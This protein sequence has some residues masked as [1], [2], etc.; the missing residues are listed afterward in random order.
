MKDAAQRERALDVR[1]SFIVQAPAGSGKTDLLVRRFLKLLATAKKPEEILAITFTKK[2]AAEM[3]K[4]ILKELPNSAEVAHRLRIQTIDAFCAALTRQV[5]VLARFGAQ[6]EIIE[7][8]RPLYKEAAGR[9]FEE[10]NPATERLLAHLDNNIPLAT[11]QLAKMLESR[12]R[13]LRKT[14]AVPTRQELEATLVSE[15]NR[16]L[17]KAKALYPKASEALARGF[18]TQKG[19]WTKR[20]PPPPEFV[21][22]A[23][24][25]E[26]LWA[27]YNMPPEK[28]ED[29]Q[30]EALEAILALLKPAVA[31]LKVLFGERG[32]AD[33]TEFAHGALAA[34]GSVDDPSDL[35]LSLDQKISHILVDEFQDTSL[36]QYELLVK[37][38]SGWSADDGRT[39]F[40]VGDPM[41]SIYRFREAEVSLFLRAKH[42]GVGSVS[43]EPIELSTNRRS[44]EGLVEWFNAAFPR[45]L[46]SQE[47]QTSGAVPYL[48]ATPFEPKL[49]G[50]AVSWHCGYDREAEAAQVVSIVKSS[51]GKKAI[52]VRNRAHLDEIVPALKEAGVRF[53]A[54]DIEQLGEKQVV[55]DLYALTRALLHLGDRIAWLALLR[56]PWC[57]LTLADLLALSV[58]PPDKGGSEFTSGGF[59]VFDLLNDSVHLS[60]DGYA[61]VSRLRDVLKPLIDNRLRGSLRERVEGA[62]LALGGP[63]CVESATDL[64][65]AEIFLD[66]LERLEEA[67]EVDLAALEDRIKGRLYALPDVEAP[68]DAVEIMTIHR[69]KG[70]EFDHVIVPGLDRLPRSGPKPLLVWKSLV[71][72]VLRPDSGVRSPRPPDKGAANE[73]SGGSLLLAP[74]DETGAGED[75]TYKYVRELDKDAD[76]IESG[77][78]FY[79]AATRAKQRLHLL[80]CAKA[81]ED[82][83]ARDPSKR[84]L[85]SKIWW[86]ARAHFGPAPADAIAEPERMPIRDVLQRLPAGF[87]VP[88]APTSVKWS[89]PEDGR[90]EEEIEFSWAGETARHVGTVVHRWLQRIADDELREWDVKR[91]DALRKKFRTELERRGVPL[92]DIKASLEAVG[93]G[94]KNAISD[95]RGR[96]ILGPHLE[97]RSEH[98]LRVSGKN[99]ARNYVIDRLFRDTSGERWIVD[100]KISSHEGGGVEAFLD[101]Q[102]KRYE[103]Q[104][105]AYAALFDRAR[106]GLYFPLLRGW[107]RWG[108]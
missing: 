5:P 67:G 52:L 83:A 25:R 10:F 60:P 63:A 62:W 88:G 23:G 22:I 45:V 6:P 26:A 34:L 55:Q 106:L 105:N 49:D 14:G 27:L 61:R 84:S 97:A 57:G 81:T 41:Q 98:R 92:R 4:R 54:L 21:Q 91:V 19:E 68:D 15:R 40:L 73:V 33:F 18:L 86:Q 95:E 79:V 69:A 9:V 82:L 89:A 103:P 53:K 44:Q 107:R 90:Q 59:L 102:Q 66:E 80:A 30:W 17:H 16:L 11:D 24:L 99:G 20:S 32:Q 8:A 108:A 12:D 58:G 96:W 64:E 93:G 47:D 39:L 100:F 51:P 76:D 31:Q 78:L 71:S 72:S 101:E 56:A 74:I 13:W 1:H 29:R 38:T 46:P 75:P 104:L 36:S 37:L 7:D 28:Y 35:L 50:T 2:A 43:L 94:L 65:D 42:S 3:R 85:L 77:R 70:L 48:P 87:A